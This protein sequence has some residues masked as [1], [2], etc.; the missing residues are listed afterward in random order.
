MTAVNPATPSAP[1]V[2]VGAPTPA[3]RRRTYSTA[4]WGVA[5]LILTEATIF[6]VL[7]AAYFFL[8]ASASEWPPAGISLPD[9]KMSTPFSFVLWGSSIPIVWAEVKL[10]KGELQK[11]RAGLAI[12]FFMGFAFLLYTARSFHDLEFGWTDNAYGSIVYTI[13]GLH[14]LHVLV[15]VV[16]NAVIQLKARLGRYDGDRHASAEVF[17][18]YW[19]FVDAV[20]LVV[21]PSLF[22]S[23]HF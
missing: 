16:M 17:F 22:L 23:E 13:V 6:L 11:F 9:L 3:T 1:P 2:A 5:M 7:I 20:W 19:H 15:G 10:R 18:L 8:R 21:W 4:W 12:S 14:A